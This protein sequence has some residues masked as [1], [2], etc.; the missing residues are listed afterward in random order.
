M[1][2]KAFGARWLASSE[3][4]CTSGSGKDD[5]IYF[6]FGYYSLIVYV[7]HDL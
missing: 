7:F 4:V 5:D 2:K 1:W 6:H 3:K